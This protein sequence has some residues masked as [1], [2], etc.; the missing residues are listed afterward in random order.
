MTSLLVFEI[1]CFTGRKPQKSSPKDGDKNGGRVELKLM[2]FMSSDAWHLESRQAYYE[3]GRLL[4]SH[5][6]GEVIKLF[7]SV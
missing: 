1:Q 5:T 4:R 2:E 6:F 3:L 7:T